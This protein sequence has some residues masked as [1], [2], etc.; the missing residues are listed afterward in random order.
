MLAL[1]NVTTAFE[2]HQLSTDLVYRKPL[3]AVG[4]T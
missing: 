2:L 3:A 4:R 1:L